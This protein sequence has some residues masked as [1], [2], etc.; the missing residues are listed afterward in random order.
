MP[1]PDIDAVTRLIEDA[2]RELV[3]PRFRRLRAGDIEQKAGDPDNLVTIV[4]REVEVRVTE[5]LRELRPDA[6]VIGEEAAEAKR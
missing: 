2:S 3:M 6:A 5:R 1:K 4:D